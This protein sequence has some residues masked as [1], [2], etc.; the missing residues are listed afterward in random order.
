MIKK[1]EVC[2]IHIDTPGMDLYKKSI[3]CSGEVYCFNAKD[4]PHNMCC[5]E[6]EYTGMCPAN[7]GYRHGDFGA[8][9]KAAVCMFQAR[10]EDSYG[11]PLI[12]DGTV[13]A[14]TWEALFGSKALSHVQV[15]PE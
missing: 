6:A 3:L 12:V 14:L 9:T 5:R 1:Y 8:K 4:E 10:S 15:S 7:V 13:G 2:F 11:D